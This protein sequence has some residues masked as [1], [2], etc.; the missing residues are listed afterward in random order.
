MEPEIFNELKRY[1]QAGGNPVQ[2]IDLLSRNYV[3]KWRLLIIFV[4]EFLQ[5]FFLL[6]QR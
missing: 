1:F 3:G 2:V 4:K 6:F 5:K